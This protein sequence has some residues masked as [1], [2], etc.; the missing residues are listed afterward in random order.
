MEKHGEMT[1]TT[2]NS[3]K[4]LVL[5]AL[6]LFGMALPTTAANAPSTIADLRQTF[7]QP[8]A[9]ARMMVRWWWFGSAVTKPELEKE[10]RT[11]KQGGFGG[12][13]VQPVYPLVLDGDHG[14]HNLPYL[15]DGFLDALRFAAETGRAEGMRFDLTLCSGWPYGGPHIPISQASGRLRVDR[16][17]VRVGAES[18]DIPKLADGDS[19]VAAFLVHGTP[20]QFSPEGI[21]QLTEVAGSTVRL[22]AGNDPDRVVLFFIASHTRQQVKRPAV[23]AEGL[24]LDHYSRAAID[25]HLKTV[26]DRLLQA[27]GKNVPYAVFSD[28][29]E[30]Y[31]ADW[32]TDLLN[33]FRKRRGYDLTPYLPALA[34]NI[35]DKTAAIRHDWG[36]TLTEL[37]EENYLKPLTDWAHRKG[38]QFRS[39]T[40]GIPPVRLSSNALVDLA[41]GEG[42]QWRRF[43]STRWASSANHLYNRPV[44]S[45]E[46]FTWL[47]SPVFR[48]TPL[49]MKAE[50]DIH[51]LNGINQ[52][53]CHGWPYSPPE[54][55]EPGWRFY[56]AAVF[57]DHNPWWMVMPDIARYM[58]RVSFLL[59]QGQPMNDVAVY[60]PTDDAWA[61]F[62]VGRTPSINQAMEGLIGPNVIPQILDAGYNFDFIDDGAIAQNGVPQKILVLPGVERI[63]LATLRKL[64]EF[65]RKGGTVIA[66]RHAPSLAPGL[67]DAESETAKIRQLAS[68]LRVVADESKLGEALHAVL[69]PDVAAAPEIGVV[70]RKLDYADV[71][72]LANTSNHPVQSQAVFRIQGLEGAWWDPMTGKVAK[73]EGGTH[74]ALNLAPYES[75]VLVF[76]KDQVPAVP[77][78]SGVPPAPLDLSAGWTLT[79]AGA[80]TEH[81]DALRSWTDLNGRK[82]FSG[83]GVYQRT[84]TV[85]QAMLSSGHPIY[86]TLGEGTPVLPA[87]GRG[88]AGMRAMLEAPVHEAA[89]V[90]VN[91]KRAGAVW[92]APYEVDVTGLLHAGDNQVSIVVANLALN[93]MAKGPLPDYTALNAKYGER[94]QAQDMRSVQPIDSGLLGPIRLV[95][96]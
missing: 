74:L 21:R 49:D 47:H 53:V 95:A 31:N 65:A 90:S 8:P 42:A 15:S 38:T 24:V 23:G 20:R 2:P 16:V 67:Q 82:F 51:F 35:G 56:A 71:Y 72:F 86:L 69:P 54:A 80:P 43:S 57:N 26:G 41:E 7:D 92:S 25:L 39:Q 9:D 3:L 45:S 32:T 33:E 10:I 40:Y 5:P 78:V 79:F 68:S 87:G 6:C 1:M 60:L 77:A 96:R 37:S 18:V 52:F 76:S 81:L 27:V 30:V 75:R 12:F 14:L 11:M 50:A 61:G 4:R 66:T 22:P 89:V 36:Q 13:E 29:L 59:R 55:G 88:G 48:A 91:G 28:S 17:E 46:T 70:H 63:P 44:T 64:E 19:F 85:P 34:G 58:Q 94:F 93:E 83:Q 73:A 62:A 84:V